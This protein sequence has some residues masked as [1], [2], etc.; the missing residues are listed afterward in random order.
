MKIAFKN[1]L[2]T[3]KRYKVASLL[4]IAGLALAFAAF[5]M[6]MAQVYSSMTFNR[7]IKDCERV[8]MVSPYHEHLGEW[9]ENVPNP[10]CYE[11]AAE[12][13]Y[14]EAIASMN[15][16]GD[17]EPVWI[18]REGENY[19]RNKMTVVRCTSSILDVFSFDII[20]G[21][22]DDFKQKDAVVV[23][24]SAADVMG[25]TV[26][27]I[28]NLDE[29]D[30]R[31]GTPLT[32]VALFK[33]F[34]ENTILAG[35]EAFRN[36]NREFGMV[37]NNWNYSVF[38][39]MR[40]GADT[41]DYVSLWQKKYKE[42][43][44][45]AYAEYVA[46]SGRELSEEQ[47]NSMF[48]M[49][50]RLMPMDE[51]YFNTE[52]RYYPCG[53][54]GVTMTML[55][56]ALVIVVVAFINFVNFFMALVPVRMRS[57]NICKVFGAG[58]WTLRMNFFFEAVGLVVIALAV[59]LCAVSLVDGSVVSEYA[60]YSLAVGDNVAAVV[61]VLLI[62][63]AMAVCAAVYPAFYITRFNA[64]MA[65]KKGFASSKAGRVLRAGLVAVQFI[66]SMVL[67]I[68]ALVFSMQYE[69]MIRYDVGI[70]RE[71]LL[72]IE[73]EDLA[74]KHEL[75]V[76]KLAENPNIAAVTST[77]W[78]IFASDGY[79]GR[80]IDGKEI[81]MQIHYVRHNAPEVFGIPVIMGHGFVKGTPGYLIT[82]YT[83][84][85]TGLGIG[86]KWDGEEVV[87]VIPHVNF[88]GA[89]MAKTNTMF[90][91]QGKSDY[92]KYFYVRL[93][94]NVDVEAVYRD[95]CSIA[96][97]IEPN[98]YDPEIGFVDDAIARIYGDTKKQT[99]LISMFAIIAVVISLMGVFGI[100]LF[101]TQHRRSEIAVRKVYGATVGG[102]VA[103]FNRRYLSIIAFCFLIAA[104]LAWC[105]A[106]RWLQQ[107]VNRI[108]VALWLPLAVLVAVTVVTVALVTLRSLKAATENPAE[109]VKSN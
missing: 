69:Y 55:A 38:V 21:N 90:Y 54:W 109:V 27:S 71:N 24:Q 68:L 87:G 29:G 107:F 81:K 97:E 3:L 60:T 28:I 18:K 84:Q 40:P 77:N 106:D 96:K 99:V 74:T 41:D 92:R 64:S 4:N 20:A 67:M 108:E 10:I 8:Y 65:V 51:F 35:R 91:S 43:S 82:D 26:G 62:A 36:D 30:V 59:A 16:F 93:H 76:E 49:P 79:N 45:T 102:V 47:K 53:S 95:I 75:F 80:I 42:Y 1:F 50:V 25:I 101:E 6:I 17:D 94:K 44:Q 88:V 5:Y 85:A 103:M 52:Y 33:D 13:P 22:V 86:D 72:V 66:V 83:S 57:V 89:N 98:A 37:N 46:A 19:E 78:E 11:T 48:N 23:S 39:K 9:A 14:V 31:P 34:P 70:D 63:L 12:L 104:P 15:C 73:S 32:V 58:Q 56:I 2:T 7:A 100:V 105:I 61:L